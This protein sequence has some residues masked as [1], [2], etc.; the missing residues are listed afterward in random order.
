MSKDNLV[1]AL[2]YIGFGFLFIIGIII[3]IYLIKTIFNLGL[4]F[5][6]FVRNVYNL[7][8]SL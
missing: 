8:C 7:V 2:K 1:L 4:Y 6:T 5:G 3:G